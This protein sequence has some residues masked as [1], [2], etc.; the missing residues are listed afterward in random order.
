MRNL[1]RK[2]SFRFIRHGFDEDRPR[3]HGSRHFLR[4]FAVVELQT[5]INV[6][7]VDALYER[8]LLAQRGTLLPRQKFLVHVGINLFNKLRVSAYSAMHNA[9]AIPP[10]HLCIPLAWGLLSGCTPSKAS[11][12]AN[13]LCHIL[14]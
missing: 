3:L 13:S 5:E 6:F 7:V 14:N 4:Q 10:D 9:C 12:A 11:R 8:T 2:H 1:L